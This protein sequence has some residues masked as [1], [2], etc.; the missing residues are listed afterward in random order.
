VVGCG[1]LQISKTNLIRRSRTLMSVLFVLQVL[2]LNLLAAAPALHELIHADAGHEDHQC[3]VTLYA[4]GHV[5]TASADV[6]VALPLTLVESQPAVEIS[7]FCSTV[8]NLP[9]GRAPPVASANS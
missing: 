3:A 7:F 1:G 8:E 5:D 4:H 2:F 9:A 6:P